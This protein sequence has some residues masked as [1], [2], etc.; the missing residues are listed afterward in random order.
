MK[1]YIR[2]DPLV[3][4]SKADYSPAQFG[5]FIKVLA[6][7]ARQKQHGRFRSR[8]AL[9][10][11]LPGPYARLLPHLFAEG[12]LV[13]LESGAVYVD[14]YDEWQEGDHTVAERMRRLRNRQRNNHRNGGVT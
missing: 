12:D 14:G 8:R 6:L 4:E 3:D 7:A 11:I 5:A 9:E 10:M 13:E 2:L 1:A